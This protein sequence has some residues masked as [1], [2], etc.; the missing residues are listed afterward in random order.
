[1]KHLG[2]AKLFYRG[3]QTCLNPFLLRCQQS[4]EL[5]I[6]FILCNLTCSYYPKPCFL[7]PGSQEKLS[8]TYYQR[9]VFSK[10]CPLTMTE[11][12]MLG[13][14]KTSMLASSLPVASLL[15]RLGWG[16]SK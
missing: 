15:P 12:G 16:R 11:E 13:R 4:H 3:T 14:W 10:G 6:C 5:V 2:P 8:H 1:M 9:P 7:V